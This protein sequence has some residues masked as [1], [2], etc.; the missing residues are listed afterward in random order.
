MA[1]ELVVR[2]NSI[3]VHELI[4]RQFW[5]NDEPPEAPLSLESAPII[6]LAYVSIFSILTFHASLS[7]RLCWVTPLMVLGYQRPLQATDLWK[8]D[9]SR[10]ADGMS[11]RFLENWQRRQTKAQ[12]W[13]ESLPTRRAPFRLRLWWIFTSLWHLLSQPSARSSLKHEYEASETRWRCETGRQQASLV[14][15][16]ND[17]VSGFWSG[18]A[19]KVF[20]DT[21]QLMTPLVVRALI[22]FSKEVYNADHHGGQRPSIGR[23]VGMALGLWGLTITQS[24]CQHQFFFRSMATGVLVRGTLITATYKRALK[25]SSEARAEHPNGKLMAHVSSDISRIDYC[26]QWFHAIWTA[27]IQL[28]ITLGCNLLTLCKLG[29]SAL[30]G[31]ALFVLLGPLQTWFM[32]L[33][34]LT[35]KK[36]MIWTDRRSKVLRELLSSMQIIKYFTYEQPFQDRINSIRHHEMVGVRL[37]NMIRAANQAMAYSIPTLASVLAFVTYAS[38]HPRFDPA[39]IFTALSLFNL[40]RQPLMFLPRALSSLTDAKNAA[41]RLTEVFEAETMV[42]AEN[43]DLS[44]AFAL[45]VK[46]ASF[47]WVTNRDPPVSVTGAEGVSDFQTTPIEPFCIRNLNL[48]VSRGKLVA[49][50]GG[51]GAGKSSLLQ[52]LIGEMR[53]L[54]G[55]VLFGGRIAYCQQNAWIQNAT[56]RDNILFGR[57]WDETRYWSAVEDASLMRDLEILPDGD[58][59]EIGEKGILL[60]QKQRVNIARALYADPDII[61]YD[62]PLS[63]VD[64]H[65][66]RAL[67]ES[68][69]IRVRD[70]GKTVILVTHALHLLPQTDYIYTLTQGTIVEEGTYQELIARGEDFCNLV[71]TFGAGK[72]VDEEGITSVNKTNKPS[73]KQAPQEYSKAAGTGRLEA[74]LTGRLMTSEKRKTGSVGRKVYKSYLKAGNARVTAPLTILFALVMQTSQVMSTVWLTY[75]EAFKF[76]PGESLYQGVYAG[77]GLLQALFTFGMGASMGIMSFYASKSLHRM[78]LRNIFFSPMAVFDTQPLGRIL[79]VFGKDID[80]VDNQ[81]ADSF[82][83]MAMTVASFLGSVIIIAVFF[84]YFIIT[85]LYISCR[86]AVVGIGYCSLYYRTS[87]REVKRLDSILRGLLYSHFSESL[88]GLPTIRAYKE[89]SRFIK[90]NSYYMDLENRAYLLTTTNQR[91]LAVRLDFLGGCLV[92]AVAVMAAKGGGGLTAAQIA[93]CLTY[94]TTLVQILSM[95]TRQ[96]AELENNMNAVERVLWYADTAN[97]PQEPSHGSGSITPSVEWPEHGAV[98]F[99]N[100][101]MSYRPGLNPVLHDVSFSVQGGEKV[102]IVGRTGA[103]KTSITVSLF[104]LVELASG[105]IKIDGIDISSLG[106]NAL[107]S[108]MTIIPQEPLLFAGTLRSNLDPF[109]IYEDSDLY[110]SLRRACVIEDLPGQGKEKTRFSLDTVIDE[111]GS[112]LSVGERSLISLARALVK[113]AQI[114]V[115]DEATAAVDLETDAKVQA[116]IHREFRGK[117]LLCIAHRLRTILAWDRILVLDSGSEYDTPLA[118]FDR[119]GLFRAMCEQSA[120]DREEI[121]LS[122]SRL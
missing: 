44:C 16:L 36:A 118:L 110:D 8:M 103:G 42:Q 18:G 39:V 30:V 46:D 52:A 92:F 121:V 62:D 69:I 90:E 35:R 86:I 28:S 54:S 75:W 78:A 68:A 102:G 57:P 43:V 101:C 85:S 33:S 100:V 76:G 22:N 113:R 97:I 93:L 64:A 91:W 34:F 4:C 56:L 89:T 9:A 14:R 11:D 5:R 12:E 1:E 77:L 41:Q 82:R 61:L 104:R 29:P 60:G 27:P 59:T 50:V 80:T 81:L 24:L 58:L 20:G 2:S 26:A 63:A 83:M 53:L 15:A 88:S 51:V 84:H 45:S 48:E 38:S 112:N 73:R 119:G 105:S 31:F 122:R 13:N 99:E 117:T 87:A 65:V 115:M 74:S 6:P 95:V 25:L 106:L 19:F 98:Q 107:R 72:E 67:F 7:K 109:D 55:E 37:I 96:S 71:K 47:Q 70:R 116:T 120:I 79:G 10:E 23:G 32:K 17:S 3:K 94:M 66:G 111:E 114:V 49:V 108:K 21:A 40:L